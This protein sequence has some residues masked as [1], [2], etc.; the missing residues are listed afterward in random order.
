MTSHRYRPDSIRSALDLLEEA[1]VLG[2]FKPITVALRFLP[3][4]TLTFV[5]TGPEGREAQISIPPST[6]APAAML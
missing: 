6:L 5:A 1:A 3:D 4:G 2:H